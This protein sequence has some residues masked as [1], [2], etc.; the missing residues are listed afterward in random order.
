MFNN[1]LNYL[2]LKN[3]DVECVLII[4]TILSLPKAL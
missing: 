3:I 2:M 1:V 4:F